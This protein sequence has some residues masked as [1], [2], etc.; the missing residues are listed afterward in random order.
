M[1]MQNSTSIDTRFSQKRL[2]YANSEM[3]NVSMRD[4]QL[5]AI[6]SFGPFEWAVK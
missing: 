6:Q 5:W 4:F 3:L 2:G 1:A